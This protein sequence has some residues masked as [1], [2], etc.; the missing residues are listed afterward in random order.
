MRFALPNREP[1][2]TAALFFIFIRLGEFVR[3]ASENKK[4]AHECAGLV[5]ARPGFE[6]R[7]TEPKSVVLPL[8]YRALSGNIKK[9]CKN[10]GSTTMFQIYTAFTR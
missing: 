9:G 4:P 6:P 3:H 8:Y 7:Q 10:T 1:P 5:V 2:P